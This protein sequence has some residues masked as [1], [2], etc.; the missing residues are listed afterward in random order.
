[1]PSAIVG[2]THSLTH[3]KKKRIG[4][5]REKDN[6]VVKIFL[7]FSKFLSFCLKKIFLLFICFISFLLLLL[8]LLS[9][10]FNY[11]SNLHIT[12]SFSD[13][14]KVET[15]KSLNDFLADKS[16]IDGYVFFFLSMNDSSS[17]ILNDDLNLWSVFMRWIQDPPHE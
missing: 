5:K 6:K 15:I 7:N 14:S 16:Y 1:M 17:S 9:S 10:S 3:R 13:F 2:F 11:I 8:L 4:E 12:M